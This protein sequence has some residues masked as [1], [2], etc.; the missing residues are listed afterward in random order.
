MKRIQKG[1]KIQTKNNGV[2]VRTVFKTILALLLF[3]ILGYWAIG[4]ASGVVRHLVPVF[5]DLPPPQ[6]TL[7]V[8]DRGLL[9]FQSSSPFDLDV[10]LSQSGLTTH[11]SYGT[12]HLPQ[13]ATSDHPVP[14]MILLHGS[15]G[16]GTGREDMYAQLL[17]EAGVGAFI[18]DYYGSRGL[19]PDMHYMAKLF[20][21][22]EVDAL[23][24]A[25][26][27]LALLKTHPAI[28]P[29]KI[30]L[31]GFSYGG[32]AIRMAMAQRIQRAFHEDK[33]FAVF[34]DF[35]G[36]C[37]QVPN[38]MNTNGA[39]LLTLR[40]DND[41]SNVL[42]DCVNREQEIQLAGSPVEAHIFK[43]APHAWDT[44]DA[45][46]QMWPDSPYIANCEVHY[47]QQGQSLLN[48]KPLI[49]LDLDAERSE[50][51]V[52]RFLSQLDLMDCLQYGYV[53]GQ[54]ESITVQS[55][56]VFLDFI[57]RHL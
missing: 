35:Y 12:L 16:L 57:K 27:G 43:D 46:A 55:N 5:P 42:S 7:Q 21:V 11:T 54:D 6:T 29:D 51:I 9:H 49:D 32:M 31:A 17:N 18:L 45:K 48:D 3:L 53:S 47:N 38:M 2:L 4:G 33:G 19:T 20:A 15:S 56:P 41:G 1:G 26:N 37:F 8:E 23:S 13:S 25:Y 50:R 40:G 24:D 52:A 39:P 34:A 36:P 28:D 14:V 30:G 10:L 22:S 44:V